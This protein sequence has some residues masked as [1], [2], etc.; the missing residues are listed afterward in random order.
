MIERRIYLVFIVGISR[1]LLLIDRLLVGNESL[2]RARSPDN[3]SVE[4][5]DKTSAEKFKEI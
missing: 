5:A 3:L 1:L 2:D 4:V